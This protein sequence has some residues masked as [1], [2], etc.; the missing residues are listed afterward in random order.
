MVVHGIEK[1]G[2]EDVARDMGKMN[3]VVSIPTILGLSKE[4]WQ[5]SLNLLKA[6]ISDQISEQDRG[7]SGR[8]RD[9]ISRLGLQVGKIIPFARKSDFNAWCFLSPRLRPVIWWGLWSEG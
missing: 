5:I 1:A 3:F 9:Q 4:K 8:V 6:Y 7:C 2:L